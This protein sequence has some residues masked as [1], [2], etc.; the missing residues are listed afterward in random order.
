MAVRC[1]STSF[2]TQ[3][4]TKMRNLSS[5]V[6]QGSKMHTLCGKRADRTRVLP[7]SERVGQM[8]SSK[9]API[10][11]QIVVLESTNN[12]ISPMSKT[13]V[14][15]H[16]NRSCGCGWFVSARRTVPTPA[17]HFRCFGG[18]ARVSAAHQG[19]PP[20]ESGGAAAKRHMPTVRACGVCYRVTVVS[21]S[22]PRVTGQ[23]C[24]TQYCHDR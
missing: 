10:R 17:S 13:G 8:S 9:A 24:G 23:L 2:V 18:V 16:Q 7:L 19:P 3:S 6:V 14:R 5:F 12:G 21:H 22:D 11:R 4:E 20:R 1:G 15:S